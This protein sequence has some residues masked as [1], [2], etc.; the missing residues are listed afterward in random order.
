MKRVRRMIFQFASDFKTRGALFSDIAAAEMS[1]VAI[2]KFLIHEALLYALPVSQAPGI[3]LVS[4]Q[5]RRGV[6][7]SELEQADRYRG[8]VGRR[9]DQRQKPVPAV[10]EGPGSFSGGFRQADQ[11]RP[12]A[13]N[14]GASRGKASVTQIALKCG[15]Q[16]LGHF[17]RDFRL[18]FGEL[19]SD[20][21]R[22]YG[23]RLI[24]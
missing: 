12:L 3:Q 7:R 4:G 20:T 18:A 1:R 2:V 13:G 24:S 15:F 10:Q 6:H 16:N 17:A 14:A 11:A 22:R 19:P 5:D 9:Q 23:R 21:L 8:D